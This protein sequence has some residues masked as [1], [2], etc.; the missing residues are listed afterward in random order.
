MTP[1]RAGSPGDRHH[2]QLLPLYRSFRWHISCATGLGVA[3]LVRKANSNLT[4]RDVKLILAA[5]GRK[6]DA[7]GSRG[8]M[9]RY[10]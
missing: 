10:G 1:S 2:L 5:S 4:W 7:V 3:A 8:G 9:R 6:T